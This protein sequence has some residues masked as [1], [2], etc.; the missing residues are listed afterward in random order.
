[1]SELLD[2]DPLRARLKALEQAAEQGGGAERIAKQHEA[3]KLTA[4]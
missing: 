3:G 1:M 2:Q 4:R